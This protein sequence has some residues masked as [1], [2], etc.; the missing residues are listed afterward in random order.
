MKL[1]PLTWQRRRHRLASLVFAATAAAALPG[2][3]GATWSSAQAGEPG[4]PSPSV[5]VPAAP[6]RPVMTG[7][8]V[9]AVPGTGGIGTAAAAG[10]QPNCSIRPE[11]AAEYVIPPPPFRARPSRCN[12]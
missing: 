9:V 1:A 5:S 10:V 3:W 7:L 2:T 11:V 8:V 12:V 6:G 4:G